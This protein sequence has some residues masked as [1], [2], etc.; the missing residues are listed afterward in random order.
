MFLLG[1][2]AS[3]KLSVIRAALHD[4]SASVHADQ[5]PLVDDTGTPRSVGRWCFVEPTDR[6]M[7]GH[8][9]RALS[10]RLRENGVR[11]P[12]DAQ[13]LY[14]GASWWRDVVVGVHRLAGG[15]TCFLWHWY[16][17]WFAREVVTPRSWTMV[18]R[19][20]VSPALF[21]GTDWD[22]AYVLE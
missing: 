9:R 3:V 19:E 1:V 7:L 2:P 6:T 8:I 5:G 20:Q 11:G 18:A 14:A 22:H 16:H 4:L 13:N 21:H 10:C 15:P 17:G 12:E